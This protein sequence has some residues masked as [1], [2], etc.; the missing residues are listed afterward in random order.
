MAR[1]GCCVVAV[2]L[3]SVFAGCASSAGSPRSA[4]TWL[5]PHAMTETSV[6]SPH[7]HFRAVSAVAH[8]DS[9]AFW[10]DMDLFF[11]TDRPT[12]LSR[13]HDR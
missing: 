1:L 9:R 11:Q 10:D 8:R 2:L 5:Y 12:R 6:R 3:L 7:E 13:W 4:T